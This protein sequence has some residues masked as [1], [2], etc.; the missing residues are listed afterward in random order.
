MKKYNLNNFKGGWFIGN[1]SPSVCQTE[2]FEV[3]L[4]KY[5]RG[6]SDALHFHR[7][8]IEVTLILEG[9]AEFSG[10]LVKENDI[11]VLDKN[12]QN[13]FV[14]LTDVKLCVVKFPSVPG[15]KYLVNE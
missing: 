12:E 5:K 15:D 7:E 4:K 13:L 11:I 3:A 6:E 8:A 9:T 14:A 10:N 1:F 2:K